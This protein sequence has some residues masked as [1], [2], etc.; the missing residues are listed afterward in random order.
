MEE[1]SAFN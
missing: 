1:N